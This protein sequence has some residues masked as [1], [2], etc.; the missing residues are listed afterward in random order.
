MKKQIIMFICTLSAFIFSSCVTTDPVNFCDFYFK[1]QFCEDLYVQLKPT[2]GL[3]RY[4]E[5]NDSII[6][7]I[8][9]TDSCTTIAKIHSFPSTTFLDPDSY[10]SQILITN[11]NG[12]TI[13]YENPMTNERW[14]IK[15]SDGDF[16]NKECTYI[17]KIELP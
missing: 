9:P 2:D 5:I 16:P 4:R 17:F 13:L 6:S 12:D 10:F 7:I 1:N 3:C 8:A 14:D 15:E 11:T